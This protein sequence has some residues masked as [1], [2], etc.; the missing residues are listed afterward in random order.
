MHMQQCFIWRSELCKSLDVLLLLLE[1]TS[2]HPLCVFLQ[3]QLNP[4]HHTKQDM[5]GGH[6]GCLANTSLIC[7]S[8]SCPPRVRLSSRNR[9]VCCGCLP[10]QWSLQTSPSLSLSTHSR[11]MAEVRTSVGLLKSTSSFAEAPNFESI[12]V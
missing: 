9:L 2:P 8:G 6:C 12:A 3:G 10:F 1:W 7:L 4:F 5:T 11:L